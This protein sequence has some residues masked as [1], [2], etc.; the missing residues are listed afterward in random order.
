MEYLDLDL[1]GSEITNV[2]VADLAPA[3]AGLKKLKY[4][5][6]EISETEVSDLQPLESLTS[7]Q[8]LRKLSLKGVKHVVPVLAGLKLVHFVL[9][10]SK[11]SDDDVAGLIDVLRAIPGIKHLDLSF[12]HTDISNKGL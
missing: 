10:F 2:G 8:F 12:W 5:G 4:F 7:L 1:H 9:H 3:L 6:L 11:F